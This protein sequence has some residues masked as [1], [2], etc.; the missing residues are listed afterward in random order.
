MPNTFY[1]K[2]GGFSLIEK[3]PRG[4]ISS[5][6][7]FPL[8]FFLL[9]IG[10]KNLLYRNDLSKLYLILLVTT[11]LV[12]YN[13]FIG[14][15]AWE[16]YGFA[17]R[18]ITPVIPLVFVSISLLNSKPFFESKIILNTIFALISVLSV[19]S[20]QLTINQ[21]LG[22]ENLLGNLSFG[23]FEISYIFLF[24]LFIKQINYSKYIIAILFTFFL[25]STHIYYMIN[26]EVQIVS[27]DLLNIEIGKEIKNFTT[28]EASI[29]VFWAGNIAYYSERKMVDF[30]GKSDSYIAKNKPV[31]ELVSS[32][33]NFNDFSF[34]LLYSTIPPAKI[35]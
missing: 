14:G 24:I 3:I 16:V 30:L 21:L 9:F 15:D 28:S 6:K 12:L 23:I 7:I 18:F 2:T 1:L 10:L 29:G 20:L 19:F 11:L 35:L 26:T 4:I 5:L 31:R 17:N 25:S 13:I 33:Y 32:R 8:L 27:T 34:A 22:F